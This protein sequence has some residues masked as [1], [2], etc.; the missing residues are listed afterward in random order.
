MD[1]NAY[2]LQQRASIRAADYRIDWNQPS[3]VRGGWANWKGLVGPL[4]REI[5]HSMTNDQTFAIAWDAMNQA[6]EDYERCPID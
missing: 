2:D 4:T 1:I 3:V 6:K 5:W